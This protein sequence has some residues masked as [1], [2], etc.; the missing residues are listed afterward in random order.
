MKRVRL[1]A[2]LLVFAFL[3][4]ALS[5]CSGAGE[6]KSEDK[7]PLKIA[8]VQPLSGDA[9]TYGLMGKRAFELAFEEINTAGGVK[10]R[11]L[12]LVVQ[13]DTGDPKQAASAAQ[14]FADQKDVLL[15]VGS[16]LSS[17]TLAMVP[18]IDK[19]KLPQVV[20]SSSS[21]KLSGASP[22]FFRMAVLDAELGKIMA[23]WAV[24][25]K[26]AK[27]V[28]DL[29]VNNDYGTLLG[30]AFTDEVK[31]LGA[32]VTGNYAYLANDR[33][34][35]A[36]LTKIKDE[37]P[38]VIGLSSTYTDAALIVKQARSMGITVPFV[39]PA[40]LNSQKFIDIAGPAAEG[41]IVTASF[42]ADN[43]D[44]KVQDF[45]KKFKTK[46]DVTADNYAAL[47]Y[48]EAYLIADT[49]KKAIEANEITREGVKKALEKADYQGVTGK[50]TF[51]DKH[52]WVRPYLFITV[53]DGKFV[54][55]H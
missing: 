17:N 47:A 49:F 16:S 15:L 43:P 41:I 18:I 40:S 7:S 22:Y 29:Y 3:V 4:G 12:E 20:Y 2:V 42:V 9:A 45:V 8:F 32:E 51:N 11:K 19:A 14:K 10:G 53:K 38:D 39:G 24:K 33:D 48:D 44:P 6:K 35:Q 1:V 13:D 5:G 46:Y 55:A 30:G 50:V 37:N 25:T 23:S 26:G 21:P 28:A 34:F 52:E 54:M 27:K 36:L 31:K